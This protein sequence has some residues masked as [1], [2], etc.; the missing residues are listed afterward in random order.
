MMAM[1]SVSS[2]Y[3]GLN[4]K[5]KAKKVMQIIDH[6]TI[7]VLIA[8]TY[9]P[10][11]LVPLRQ[12]NPVIGWVIFGVQWSI[13]ALGVTLNSIDLKKYKV[14]SMICYLLMGWC[15]IF[16]A[17]MLPKALSTNGVILLLAGGISYT[18]G[19]VFYAVGGKVRYMHAVFHV[20][21]VIGSLMHF[22]TVLLYAL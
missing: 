13:A 5:R 18:V 8:G 7:F 20:F 22:L 19:A 1:Y 21:V 12:I 16:T 6:C 3:H 15:I 4:P 2:V 17:P 10:F 11:A 9:T 14:F